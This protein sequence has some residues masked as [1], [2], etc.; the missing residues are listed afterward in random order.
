M[1]TGTVNPSSITAAIVPADVAFAEIAEPYD[2]G[3]DAGAALDAAMAQAAGAGRRIL[4][5]F[6]ASWCPDCRILSGML[7][8]PAIA[9]FLGAH[10]EVV[11]IGVGRYDANMN[12]AARF[13]LSGLEGVPALIVTDANG[14][15]MNGAE[16]FSWRSARTRTPQALADDLARWAQG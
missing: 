16:V 2:A 4:V 9:D 14:A 6:G 3:L 12:L 15:V 10:Y 8:I 5:I 13:C 1:S 7:A 11:A